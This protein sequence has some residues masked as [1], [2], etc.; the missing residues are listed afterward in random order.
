MNAFSHYS[1]TDSVHFSQIRYLRL[2]IPVHAFCNQI[3]Q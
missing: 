3:F 1:Q 2:P